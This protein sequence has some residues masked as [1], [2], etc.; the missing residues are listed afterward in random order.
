VIADESG[1][2]GELSGEVVTSSLHGA[3][4]GEASFW[5]AGSIWLLAVGQLLTLAGVLVSSGLFPKKSFLLLH[6]LAGNLGPGAVGVISGLAT[7]QLFKL[8]S[9]PGHWRQT[10][11]MGVH[12]G[13]VPVHGWQSFFA[14]SVAR[15]V[16]ASVF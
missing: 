13:W 16:T 11:R 8:A 3:P 10:H 12:Q 15:N 2:A 4:P 1:T 9:L 7:G 14:S 5:E 6:L